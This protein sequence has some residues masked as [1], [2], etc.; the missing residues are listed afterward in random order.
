MFSKLIRDYKI[1]MN[2]KRRVNS[3]VL[4]SNEEIVR[5]LDQVRDK[6]LVADRTERKDDAVRFKASVET[7]E[8]LIN[9]TK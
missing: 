6:Y 4:R 2:H 9:A 1:M 8:W 7:L 5:L 3:I